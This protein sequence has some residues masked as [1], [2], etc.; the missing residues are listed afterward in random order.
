MPRTQSAIRSARYPGQLGQLH[1]QLVRHAHFAQI[2]SHAGSFGDHSGILRIGLTLTAKRT[3]HGVDHP[4]G[5]IDHQLLGAQQHGD[6]HQRYRLVRSIAHRTRSA[7]L[8][9]RPI[10]CSIARCSLTTF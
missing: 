6:Q 5:H 4:A 3:R 1:N 10:N 7:L 8:R 9:A 2:A